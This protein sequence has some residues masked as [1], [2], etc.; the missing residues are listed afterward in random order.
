MRLRLRAPPARITRA[1]AVAVSCTPAA[2]SRSA[3]AKGEVPVAG[4]CEGRIGKGTL[5][6]GVRAEETRQLAVWERCTPMRCVCVY[7]HS[8]QSLTCATHPH[9]CAALLS[10]L[11]LRASLPV[12]QSSHPRATRPSPSLTCRTPRAMPNAAEPGVALPVNA[13]CKTRM[14]QAGRRGSWM[15]S[16]SSAETT[17]PGA[18]WG[19]G[20]RGM[21]M[22]MHVD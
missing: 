13:S 4:D 21:V 6:R 7:P 12:R 5:I 9:L 16:S 3:D 20:R 18:A 2:V 22:G 10:R 15:V 11:L 14:A 8:P 19:E 1:I 17:T